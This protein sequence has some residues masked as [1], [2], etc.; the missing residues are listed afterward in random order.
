[1][2]DFSLRFP[3][4]G[5]IDQTC[6]PDEARRDHARQP[7][8]GGGAVAT[9][10]GQSWRSEGLPELPSVFLFLHE[11]RTG[12]LFTGLEKAI[13]D[14]DIYCGRVRRLR[15]PVIQISATYQGIAVFADHHT[16]V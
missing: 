5:S 9:V 6:L 3:P 15:Q 4:L 2:S 13:L 1:M 11:A 14:A 12:E 16:P 8:G 7:I 10:R